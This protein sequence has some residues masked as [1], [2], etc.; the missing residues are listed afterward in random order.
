ML[1]DRCL[2]V[3]PVSNVGVLWP[4]GW[5]DQDETWHAGR[6]QPGN[7]L[8]DGDSAPPPQRGGARNFWPKAVMAN[9]CINQD[10]T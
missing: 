8:L 6:S 1:S 5:M 4:N 10:A 3:C 9:G 7:I 2:S